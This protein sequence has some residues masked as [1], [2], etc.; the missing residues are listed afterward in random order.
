MNNT[1]RRGR[2]PATT[3]TLSARAHI[4]LTD[5]EKNQLAETC[6]RLQLTERDVLLAGLATLQP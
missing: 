5:A 3:P 4:R 2:P 6:Q 1:R